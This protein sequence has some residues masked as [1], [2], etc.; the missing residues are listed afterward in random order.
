MINLIDRY[1]VVNYIDS[2]PISI[3]LK[4]MKFHSVYTMSY[5]FRKAMVVLMTSS[6][7]MKYLLKGFDEIIGE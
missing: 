2:V 6:V 5:Q 1:S 3:R 4:I 7:V